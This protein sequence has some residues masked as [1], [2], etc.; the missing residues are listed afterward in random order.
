[1]ESEGDEMDDLL[2]FNGILAETGAP[3]VPPLTSA[4]LL[5]VILRQADP[6][7]LTDLRVRHKQD[8]QSTEA[9]ERLQQLLDETQRKL[10][11]QTMAMGQP[12]A[13]TVVALAE[14]LR[15]LEGELRL[16]QHLG[17]KEG[18]D[19]SDLRQAG[20]GVLFADDADPKL[21]EALQ[22]LIDLRKEQAGERFRIYSGSRGYRVKGRD[23]KSK[24][25]VRN[26]A[27][28]AGPVSP[29][30]VPYYLLIVGGPD[31]IPFDFQHQLDV[32]YAVGRVHFD[33]LEEY[34]SYARSVVAAE[35]KAPPRP[36]QLTFFEVSNPGDRA[37]ESSSRQLVAPLYHG[38][39]QSFQG[40]P[41]G[42]T[43]AKIPP[44]EAGKERLRRLLS[45]DAPALLFTASHGM[46]FKSGNPDQP[47]RQGALLCG[48]WPGPSHIGPIPPEFYFAG[49][50]LDDGANLH[51]MMLFLFAC[52]GAGTP[53]LDS[54][55]QA[56]VPVA[57]APAP[58]V[59]ALPRRLLSHPAGGA[60]A[61]IGHVDRAWSYS[62][63]WSGE[64]Q[65]VHTA[66]IESTL[67]RL[68]NGERI[69]YAMEYLNQRYAELA[70]VLSDE[71]GAV[72][73]MR[74]PDE[75]ALAEIWTATHDAR[76]YC[77]LGD[78]A[79]RFSKAADA[80]EQPC[81]S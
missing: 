38:F 40:R 2:N 15:K 5:R 54:F 13:A 56:S 3:E 79:V 64:A 17:V 52:Y 80:K 7:N 78:P 33:T 6:P 42:W 45:A 29:E 44:E 48:D 19:A 68:L 50:D 39:Q 59:S 20:W 24:F 8:S 11:E 37:T 46:G 71:L 31:K 67:Q 36:R 43:L 23:T 34:A 63:A 27:T 70:T 26:G 51:G 1:M 14:S 77:V 57:R 62:F 75:R 65:R 9:V 74:Q 69:G 16:R 76:G 49:S 41:C 81:A 60:L 4:Q 28:A 21:I 53:E 25:L 73:N 35:Q 66:A 10:R 55:T 18:I 32:Q 12:D 22:P 30:A 58:F 47:G 72:R 61:V